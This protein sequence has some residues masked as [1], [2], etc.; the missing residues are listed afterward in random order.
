MTEGTRANIAD[1]IVALDDQCDE[2]ER[3][4]GGAMRE[5]SMASETNDSG[6]Q[7]VAIGEMESYTEAYATLRKAIKILESTW[8][9]S[10][11]NS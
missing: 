9:D 6:A 5:Y 11:C 1:V 7:V 8:S 4:V 10:K 3:L 2:I